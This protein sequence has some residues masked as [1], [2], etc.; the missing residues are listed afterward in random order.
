YIYY[1]D[2]YVYIHRDDTKNE[3]DR[4]IK[5][6]IQEFMDNIVYYLMDYAMGLPESIISLINKA[7]EG[8]GFIDAAQ[9][10]NNIFIGEDQFEFDLNMKEIADNND[11]GR[12]LIRLASVLVAKTDEDGNKMYVP[13]IYQIPKF[14]FVAVDVV[15]LN[16]TSLTL[17]NIKQDEFGD[18]IAYDISLDELDAYLADF[19]ANYN[20]DEEYIYSKGAWISNGKIKH[21]VVYD[22]GLAGDKIKRY[23]EG[24]LLDFPSYKDDIVTIDVDGITKYYKI[25]GW[26]EDAS[27]LK[28]IE[29][30]Y[31]IYMGNKARTFYAKTKEIT[32]SIT[33]SSSLDEEITL[34]HYEGFDFAKEI[35]AIYSIH[36]QAGTIYKFVGIA[37]EANT[38]VDVNALTL[39]EYSYTVVWEEVHYSFYALYDGE[40]K[41]LEDTSEE[42]FLSQDYSI[43]RN[44]TY[45]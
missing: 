28:P 32:I 21:N 40:E 1:K 27:Y 30:I 31:D 9:C 38:L 3:N 10:I 24:D 15:K 2:S 5:I 18:Y 33:L 39:G 36:K 19:D 29:S 16:S 20:A 41:L 45:Y 23:A 35:E 22:M 13:M 14:E 42:V 34:T 7:P 11:L 37:D 44:G 6:H 12:L 4:K 43:F 25:L 8:D 17:S 26:Y